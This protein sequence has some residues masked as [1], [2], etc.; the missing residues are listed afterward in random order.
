MFQKSE[1]WN[2]IMHSKIPGQGDDAQSETYAH[3]LQRRLSAHGVEARVVTFRY[4]VNFREGGPVY[5]RSAVVYRSETTPRI[6]WWLMDATLNRPVWLPN[7]PLEQ[8]LR[9]A[10]HQPEVEVVPSSDELSVEV[11]AVRSTHSKAVPSQNL[12]A[13]FEQKNG[14]PFDAQSAADR[15]KMSELKQ[16]A[17]R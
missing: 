10:E 17:P 1:A 4:G 9:F 15:Q 12:P 13:L 5:T 16:A 2:V 6:P 8:Q 11:S 3:E 7:A 14:T